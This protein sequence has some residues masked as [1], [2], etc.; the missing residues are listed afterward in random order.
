MV[1]ESESLRLAYLVQSGQK[2]AQ[3]W[4]KAESAAT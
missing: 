2:I 4:F 3:F 1:K